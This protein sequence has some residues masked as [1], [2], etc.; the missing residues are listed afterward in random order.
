[1]GGFAG[2][3]FFAGTIDDVRV[4]HRSLYPPPLRCRHHMPPMPT[5]STS[6]AWTKNAGQ[7]TADAAGAANSATLGTSSQADS[8]DPTWVAG[9]PFPNLGPTATPTNTPTNAQRQLPTN[10]PLPTEYADAR[11]SPTPT[12]LQPTRRRRCRSAT[13]PCHSA[14]PTTS[15][16]PR[17]VSASRFT[18][19]AWVRPAAAAAN[20]ILLAGPMTTTVGRSNDQGRPTLWLSTNVG[21]QGVIYPTALPGGQWSPRSRRLRQRHGASVCQRCGGCAGYGWRNL[22]YL[23]QHAAYGRRRRLSL[24]RRRAGRV[25]LSS[26]VRYTAAFTPPATLAAPTPRP[27]GQWAFNEGTGQSAAGA[28]AN[29]YR[30]ARCVVGNRQR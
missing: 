2:Y 24:L 23:G 12:N 19:E 3:P 16:P 17:S 29:A 4:K 9:Y 22:A 20:G 18:V 26:D 27:L 8:A 7:L 30:H 14:A 11:P 25:R 28:S 5:P 10:T 21:W 15:C 13:S 6:G 1:M